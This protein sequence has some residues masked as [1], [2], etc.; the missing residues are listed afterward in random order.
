MFLTLGYSKITYMKKNEFK[1]KEMR[2]IIKGIT[3]ALMMTTLFTVTGCGKNGADSDKVAA[4]IETVDGTEAGQTVEVTDIT[5][6]NGLSGSTGT[7][8]TADA[9]GGSDTQ[10]AGDGPLYMTATGDANI[11]FAPSTDA[12]ILRKLVVGEQ[13]EYIAAEGDWINIRIDGEEY[14]V[15]KDYLSPV[16]AQDAD[17]SK[18]AEEDLQ[19][20]DAEAGD[21]AAVGDDIKTDPPSPKA[22]TGAGRLV[23]IDAGHQSKG[24]SEKEPLGPG[25]TQMKAKVSG[26][27]SGV[28]SGLKEYELTLQVSLKLRDEL[29]SRGYDVLMIRETNDVNISNAERA[30][31][32][33]NAGAGAFIRIH[34]NGSEN[35]GA[36]GA[37]TICQ[38][39]TNPYNA[40]LYEKSKSL[41]T[42]V[43]DSLVAATGAK[44]EKVWETD[45]MTGI[46]WCQ[47]PVTI[48][49]MGYMTNPTEDM[50]MAS[51]DYQAKIVTGIADGI[52]DYYEQ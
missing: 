10:S 23:A 21:E 20:A 51:D 39:S 44:R 34:A 32:A 45:T 2:R 36:N 6:D 47:I 50:L 25:S 9:S 31:V 30:Q 16:Y 7:D 15:H 40:S 37:M 18:K 43:L 33:N 49:E 26:G 35:S 19:E 24:N 8:G 4:H 13:V 28:S 17:A 14:Y 38:T 41:S 22:A 5:A 52:D 1:V 3:V 29:I 42:H 12:Q 27:T 11:R 46:N 48:V